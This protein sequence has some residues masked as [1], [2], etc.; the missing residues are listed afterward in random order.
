MFKVLKYIIVSLICLVL[1]IGVGGYVVL[2]NIDFNRYKNIVEEKVSEATGRA[3]HI[4]D[5]QIKASF[6][7]TVELKNITLSNAPWAG[8]KFMFNAGVIDVGVDVLPLIKGN[9]V[10]S[11]FVIKN[12]AINL[13]EK[14]DGRANWNF[15]A[16]PKTEKSTEEKTSYNFSLIKSAY[17]DEAISE[18]EAEGGVND[19]LSKIVIKEVVLENV[20]VNYVGKD[21]QP[22]SYSVKELYLDENDERNIDFKF[23]VNDGLYTGKGTFGALNMLKSEKGYPVKADVNVM[24]INVAADAILFDVMNVDNLRFDAKVKTKGFLGRDSIYRESADVTLKGNLKEI[25]GV[26][27]SV[28]LA[29]NEV[30][31]TAKVILSGKVPNVKANLKSDKIDLDSFAAPE[32]ATFSFNLVKSAEATTLVPNEVI[33]YD[34]LYAVNA[35]VDLAIA[36][37]IKNKLP[38]VNDLALNA[39]V[40]QGVAMVKITNA[41]VAKGDLQADAVLSAADKNLNINLNVIKLRLQDLMK[42]LDAQ[43]DSFSFINGSDTDLYAKLSGAGNTYASLLENLNGRV[44]LI[45][46]ESEVHLGNVGLM[47]GNIFSQLWN[48][49]NLSKGNDNLNMQ[50][51]VVRADIKDGVATMPNGIVVKADKFTVV[52]N[53]K[54]N[55][56]NDKISVSFKPFAGK[57]TDTNIAKALSSLVQLT[58]TLQKPT[59]G[60]DTANAVKNIVGATMTGPVYLGAQMI[61]ENDDSPCYTALKGTGYETRFPESSNIVK[62]TG[63]DVGQVIDGGVDMVKDTAKAL[64]NMLSGKPDKNK[65]TNGK[66]E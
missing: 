64:F 30:K 23:N 61:M 18:A 55:L 31:G 9:Y 53:G 54:V 52:A 32:K 17:A 26:I 33:P 35:D 57:L 7:P 15:E 47:K 62:S 3:F 63:D 42:V 2:K 66:T 51:A 49:L 50:C 16:A 37:I 6:T 58:G 56:K 24:G 12:A 65:E 11:K 8:E 29:G 13:E 1:L 39:K 4:G 21:G 36:E 40:N 28:R 41:K 14:K 43:S 10:I 5:I 44:A 34:V 48:T 22:Q 46:D 38:F 25:D 20:K 27:N 19:I 59:I 60:V 45:V